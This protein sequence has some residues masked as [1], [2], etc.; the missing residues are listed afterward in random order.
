[1][2]FVQPLFYSFISLKNKNS[3]I[4]LYDTLKSLIYV[5]FVGPHQGNNNVMPF[6]SPITNAYVEFIGVVIA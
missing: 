6:S 2:F 4:P 1:M 5:V 3:E